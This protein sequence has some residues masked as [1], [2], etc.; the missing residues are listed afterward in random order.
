MTQGEGT[1]T[2]LFNS[3]LEKVSRHTVGCGV[4]PDMGLDPSSAVLTLR[5]ASDKI[6][7]LSRSK[8]ALSLI[9]FMVKAI[10][11]SSLSSLISAAHNPPPRGGGERHEK[12][13]LSRD[14]F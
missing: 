10:N 1:E 5:V 11:S 2:L 3:H 8:A 4:K 6:F 7:N 13:L 9:P 14:I 12:S